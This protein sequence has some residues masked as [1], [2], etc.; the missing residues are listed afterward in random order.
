MMKAYLAP[1][2]D[3]TDLPFRLLCQ[4]YGAHSCCYPMANSDAIGRDKERLREIDS[5]PDEKNAGIQIVGGDPE[6]VGKTAN[7]ICD[8]FGWIDYINLNAGCPSP[9]TMRSGGGSDLLKKPELIRQ[10]LSAIRRTDKKVSI[11]IRLLP[12]LTDT[13]D[14]CRMIQDDGADFIIV[15]GRTVSQGYSGKADHQSIMKINEAVDIPVIGNGDIKTI[16]QGEDLVKN[17]ICKS[18]MIG[19]AAM[20]NPGLF[21]GKIPD[22][23][24]LLHQYLKIRD[25]YELPFQLHDTRMKAMNF[26]AGEKNAS[27][28]RNKISTAKTEEQILES[29]SFHS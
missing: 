25:D 17:G 27:V 20:A 4:K 23:R 3:F 6:F 2:Y 5:H 7:L 26:V 21:G 24:S 8:E 1:I 18:V 15:H 14:L 16:K 29:I 22:P 11:K 10:I 9:R 12:S 13:I 19:R 28:A